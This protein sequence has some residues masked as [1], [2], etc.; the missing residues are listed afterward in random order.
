M[1]L[2]GIPHPQCQTIRQVLKC[3]GYQ[4]QHKHKHKHQHKHQ[5]QHQHQH[6]HQHY[7]NNSVLRMPPRLVEEEE[8]TVAA[9]NVIKTNII[10]IKET[11]LVGFTCSRVLS[12][13]IKAPSTKG[14]ATCSTSWK[15]CLWEC[16]LRAW[17]ILHV[18]DY[19]VAA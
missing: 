4:H 10:K 12:A 13:H 5:H 3:L 2:S 6:K 7:K 9:T 17:C 16:L 1:I 19:C 15:A 8:L 18:R 14:P 11:E